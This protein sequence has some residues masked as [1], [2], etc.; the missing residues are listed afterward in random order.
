MNAPAAATTY[1]TGT[2]T[3]QGPELPASIPGLYLRR[4]PGGFTAHLTAS[5]HSLATVRHLTADVLQFHGADRES[6]G[7]AQLV[8][9]ELV[10]NAVRACGTDVPLVVDVYRNRDGITVAVHDPAP[11][12]LPHR[13]AAGDLAESGRGLVL[14]DLLAPGW[15]VDRSPI[16]KQIRCRLV[17]DTK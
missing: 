11:D 4:R 2:M 14:L 6:T 8:L 10:G 13:T 1:G 15:T 7:A 17:A 3:E 16:G 12:Q 5:E 9:S